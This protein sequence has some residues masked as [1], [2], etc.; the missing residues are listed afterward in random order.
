MNAFRRKELSRAAELLEEARSMKD[1]EEEAHDNLP[2]SLQYSDK[3]E[4]MQDNIDMMVESIYTIESVIEQIDE[5][6]R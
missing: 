1:E 3:G 6:I 4:A 5:V 2:E